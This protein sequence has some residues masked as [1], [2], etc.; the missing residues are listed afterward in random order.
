LSHLFNQGLVSAG[1]LLEHRGF[2]EKAR[3]L[4]QGLDPHLSD[5][6][7][8][9]AIDPSRYEVVYGVIAKTGTILPDGLPLFS[10]I[11]LAEASDS[12]RSM[13]YGVSITAIHTFQN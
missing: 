1:L 8:I 10:K 3:A 6:V 5:L 13:G 7:P 4:L 9:E 2:R 11:T 12:I